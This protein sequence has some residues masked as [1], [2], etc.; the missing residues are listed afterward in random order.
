MKCGSC[1]S[2]NAKNFYHLGVLSVRCPDCGADLMPGV[3][4]RQDGYDKGECLTCRKRL[5]S[6]GCDCAW[7]RENEEGQR[8]E[9][10]AAL[11]AKETEE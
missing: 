7:Y 5:S 11:A 8:R 6:S 4:L 9:Y 2:H 1:G 10:E 3:N